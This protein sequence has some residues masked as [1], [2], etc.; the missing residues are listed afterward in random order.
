MRARFTVILLACLVM[1]P[2]V[3]FL[4][5]HVTGPSD[6]ARLEPGQSVWRVDGV[7]VTPLRPGGLRHGDVIVGVE[8]KSLESWVQGLV[9]W[10]P[11]R[12]QWHV[13]Q[14]ITYTVLR[15]GHS[16]DVPVTLET[17]PLGTIVAQ[18]WSTILYALVFLL[19]AVFVF[20]L[21]SGERAA[22]VQLLMAASMVGATTWSF[23][24][25]VSDL[26]NGIGFWLYI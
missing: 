9:N 20:V 16:L 23:G 15:H 18:E 21:R 26:I 24:L 11:A 3:V 5:L 2:G 10:N 12:P 8:G 22:R 1:L 6:G 7:I 14:T 13:G 17:Y 19:V 25:Q 4:L